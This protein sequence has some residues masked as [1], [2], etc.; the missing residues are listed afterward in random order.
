MLGYFAPRPAEVV[1]GPPAQMKKPKKPCR[2]RGSVDRKIIDR[3][4]PD[5]EKKHN[6]NKLTYFAVFDVD[7]DGWQP[8]EIHTGTGKR[9]SEVA[10]L[11]VHDFNA[12]RAKLKLKPFQKKEKFSDTTNATWFVGDNPDYNPNVFFN[13]GLGSG[14]ENEEENMGDENE[15]ENTEDERDDSEASRLS[16]ERMHTF[17]I[18]NQ[19]PGPEATN[20]HVYNACN[21]LC[22]WPKTK[23]DDRYA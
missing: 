6:E 23:P 7:D 8:F 16:T 17:E 5:I 14:D 20:M 11:L 3:T 22:F 10:S 15:E 9:E 4:R 2:W 19:S 18:G 12:H 21:F 1:P 13:R